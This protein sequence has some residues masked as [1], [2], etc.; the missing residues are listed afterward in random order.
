MIKLTLLFLLI[1][2]GIAAGAGEVGYLMG[3]R[4]QRKALPEPRGCRA[5]NCRAWQLMD[6]GSGYCAQHHH[7]WCNRLCTPA[8][9]KNCKHPWSEHASPKCLFSSTTYEREGQ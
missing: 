6:C 4:T 3:K 7:A 9:C 5:A 8:I 2:F 1:G